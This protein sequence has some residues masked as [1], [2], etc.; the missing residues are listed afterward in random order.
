ML[1]LNLNWLEMKKFAILIICFILT[2]SAFTQNAE[3]TLQFDG[4]DDFVRISSNFGITSSY[5]IEFWFKTS[6]TT[7]SCL[8][9]QAN[10]TPPTTPGSF[11]PVIGITSTGTLRAES[12]TS[13]I[14]AITTTALYNDG[15]W[16][17]VA[18]ITSAT[19]QILYVDG[20]LIGSR[21]GTLNIAFWSTTQIGTGYDA[22]SS[23]LG[24]TAGWK[25]INANIDEV[26][27]W[28]DTLSFN[29]IK[30]WCYR[31]VN[32]SH[33]Y[34]SNLVA[35]YNLDEG[36]G[37]NAYDS[38]SNSYTGTLTNFASS[39]VWIASYAP[40]ASFPSNC[41]NNL[42]AIWPAKNSN[43][44]SIMSL[45]DTI[46]GN[47]YVVFGHNNGYLNYNSSNKPSVIKK[48]LSRYWRIEKEGTLNGT[49]IFNYTGIDTTG[50]FTFK[51][52][53]DNDTNFSN[54][55]IISGVKK[56]NSSIAF[57]NI[58]FQDSSFY[59]RNNCSIGKVSI[60]I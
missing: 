10:N 59:S 49:V 18:F 21:T 44:S 26:R 9:G 50:F 22:S 12:W 45:T 7:A 40:F 11:I 34:Y 25:Y 35:Y 36:S 31:P 1:C 3:K 20:T 14:G 29:T 2:S 24:G 43:S 15:K 47:A 56:G 41:L 19:N 48:R 5:T 60:I 46:S 58:S 16:H 51:L 13:A 37:T 28:N 6:A 38:S 30:D 57:Y 17:H 27:I 54:A 23:R 52:L 53:S 32:S 8:F 42:A 33:P 55:T 39:G 4:T